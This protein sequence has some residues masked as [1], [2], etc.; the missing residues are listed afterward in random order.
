MQALMIKIMKAKG[1]ISLFRGNSS[2]RHNGGLLY[3]SVISQTTFYVMD[4]CQKIKELLKVRVK[5]EK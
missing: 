2:L 1:H 5:G 3:M 4:I